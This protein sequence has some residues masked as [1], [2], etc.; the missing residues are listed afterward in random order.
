MNKKL[1]VKDNRGASLVLVIVALLFVGIIAAITLKVTVGNNK[2]V[3]TAKET[4]K[5][6]YSTEDMVDDLKVYLQKFAN[7]SATEAYAAVLEA[8]AISGV[9]DA[10]QLEE[11]YQEKFVESLNAK[12]S[13]LS[14]NMD[15]DAVTV[16]RYSSAD[17][18]IQFD[19]FV[20]GVFNPSN[21]AENKDPVLK[22]VELKYK[23]AS[24]YE[25][26]ITTDIS[27]SSAMPVIGTMGA[28]NSLP[29]DP[30]KFIIIADGNI[31]PLNSEMSGTIIGNIYAKGNLEASLYGK[32]ENTTIKTLTLNTQYTI[33]GGDVNISDG[34]FNV[35]GL[36]VQFRDRDS[37]GVAVTGDDANVWCHNF[38]VDS[39]IATIKSGELYLKDDLTLEGDNPQFN[40]TAGG[41]IIGYST[42]NT[43]VTGGGNGVSKHQD[44]SAIVLNGLAA[45]LDISAL[46]ELFLAG[47]AYTQVPDIAGKV[48]EEEC[49]YFVQ[50]ESVTYKTLQSVY[51]IPGENIVGVYHNP[52][53]QTEFNA[54]EAAGKDLTDDTGVALGSP[55]YLSKFVKYVNGGDNYVYLYWNFANNAA[56]VNYF[57][58]LYTTKNEMLL[59]Q[60]GMINNLND[61]K[62]G[63]IKLP[64]KSKI[65]SKGNLITYTYVGGIDKIKGN[66]ATTG[67]K[68][69][70]ASKMVQYSD[71]YEKLKCSLSKEKQVGKG[72]IFANMFKTG[73]DVVGLGLAANASPAG[74]YKLTS[75][76][77]YYSDPTSNETKVA[78]TNKGYVTYGPDY[79]EDPIAWQYRLITGDG[80][81][82]DSIQPNTKYIVIST[83]DVE[84][85]VGNQFHGLIIAKGD[86][87]LIDGC[88]L[89][90]LGNFVRTMKDGT[91]LTV[92]EYISEFD[93]LLDVIVNNDLSKDESGNDNGNT[94]LRRIFNVA[95]TSGT[96]GSNGDDGN[97][98]QINTKEFS[99]NSKNN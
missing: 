89:C 74:G 39:A 93:A 36:P 90:C 11:K 38:L 13:A 17:A 75:P 88:D 61:L 22:G 69:C 99:I 10:D 33:I 47:T 78:T 3:N 42:D 73:S 63:Y 12:F 62:Y 91:A 27:F 1:L 95:N 7:E 55:K 83:G 31:E 46:D 81:K 18:S 85:N 16:G 50:G 65:S 6:F 45:G 54:W 72:D 86:V 2:N 28:S 15:V 23:D 9:A 68:P 67:A 87:K 32:K 41:K 14:N 76:V 44:S 59:K 96:A 79:S 70:D 5:N 52:M 64:N 37:S 92:P 94:I 80:V 25:T 19:S 24:G 71:W 98:V 51:L 40:S 21:P 34:G 35:F 97:L 49:G 26:L 29:Y 60:M 20:A 77:N 82:I 8:I 43:D 53:T 57:N 56:A 58:N 4:S 84:I 48:A 30:D 66:D